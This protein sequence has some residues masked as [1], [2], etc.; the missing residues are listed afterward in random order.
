MDAHAFVSIGEKEYT[1]SMTPLEVVELVAS[2]HGFYD[3]DVESDN[4]RTTL[5]ATAKSRVLRANGRGLKE[6][7]QKLVEAL[8]E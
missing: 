3:I 8:N 6:A 5:V 1:Y 2:R 4:G 7:C